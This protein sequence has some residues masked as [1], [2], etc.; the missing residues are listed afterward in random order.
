MVL[1]QKSI[2]PSETYYQFFSNYFTIE[3]EGTLPNSFYEST[4]MRIPI[5][6]RGPI[7]CHSEQFPLLILMKKYSKNKILPN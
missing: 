6:H 5:S 1:M 4:I 2:R 3:T 7:K